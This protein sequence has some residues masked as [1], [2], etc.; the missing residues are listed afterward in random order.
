MKS[1]P[2]TEEQ[3][4]SVEALV[5]RARN[6][7]GEAFDRLVRLFEKKVLKTALYLTR[8][9]DDAQDVA[10][11]VY[12]RI[13][14]HLGTYQ[15]R[16]GLERWIFRITV[17][18]ARDFHRKRRLWVPL[19]RIWA[20]VAPVDRLGLREVSNRLADA[21]RLL[22]FS[23]R[24]AFVLRELNELETS[25]VAEILGCSAVTVRGHLHGARKKLQRR[26][27]DYQEQP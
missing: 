19:E 2:V 18:A 14:R 27:R 25:E 20:H 21:L 10:Q 26:L 4:E 22:S 23:E 9:L 13:F 12:I 3:V 24:A 1:Q 11:E 17:N 6:G 8:N 16:A 15:D 7:D 5:D